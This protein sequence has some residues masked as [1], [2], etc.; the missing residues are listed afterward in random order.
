MEQQET[1]QETKKKSSWKKKLFKI[2]GILLSIVILW[3][4][5]ENFISAWNDIQDYLI[6]ANWLLIVVAIF[7][8]AFVFI[9]TGH[10]WAYMLHKLD[11]TMTTADY[12]D[13]HMTS[14]FA[15]YIPGGI[16]NIVG[17]AY[18]CTS[19]G[20]N[21]SATTASMI[22]EYVYQIISSGLFLLFFLPVFFNKLGWWLL[23]LVIVVAIG[24]LV[25]LPWLVRGGVK[26][27]AKIFKEDVSNLH[28]S[29]KLIYGLLLRYAV[30]WLIT[31]LGLV[32]WVLAFDQ[33]TWEQAF[34]LVLSYPI[35]WVVGFVSPSPNG[36]GVRE[37]VMQ[38]LLTGMYTDSLLAL[39][40]VTSRL[41]TIVGEVLSFGIF[42]PLFLLGKRHQKKRLGEK[43]HV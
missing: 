14:A 30:V 25:A 8:Y 17:K 19:K 6:N 40:T 31:G 7:V 32:L 13:I 15:R 11:Q 42:N 33:V 41:W 24:I 39:I 22:L 23:V 10:N 20:V 27:L 2:V 21:K 5:V 34:Y 9:A 38:F 1:K 18:M 37:G 3:F 29:A 35:C 36:L 12:L 43:H 4:L 26:L 28:L 16:W